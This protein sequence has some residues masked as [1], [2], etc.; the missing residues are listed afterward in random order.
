MILKV[1]LLDASDVMKLRGLLLAQ[2]ST[3]H[4]FRE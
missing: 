3:H 1:L 2:L 4:L